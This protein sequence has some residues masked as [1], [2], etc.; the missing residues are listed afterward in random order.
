[1]IQEKRHDNQET[2]DVSMD[3]TNVSIPIHSG[4]VTNTEDEEF[5]FSP[6]V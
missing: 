1:M 4:N 5:G 6:N 2:A 3:E